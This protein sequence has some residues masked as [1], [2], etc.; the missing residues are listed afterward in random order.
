MNPITH[1]K[2][3]EHQT[4]CLECIDEAKEQFESTSSAETEL[5]SVQRR[6]N[7]LEMM[8][9]PER[10]FKKNAT[11]RERLWHRKRELL[12]QIHN[13]QYNEDIE[14]GRSQSMR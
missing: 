4:E 10:E 3:A 2:T 6:I 13:P 14:W 9:S 11:K 1:Q 8:P 12:A 7:E 5:E